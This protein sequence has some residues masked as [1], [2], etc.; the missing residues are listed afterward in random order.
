MVSGMKKL[1][2]TISII[3]ALGIGAVALNTV[4]PAGALGIASNSAADP[5]ADP[6]ACGPR[7]TFKGVLDKLVTDGTIT[8]TQ[9]DAVAQAMQDAVAAKH[10][11]GSGGPGARRPMA[12]R[13]IEGMIQVSADKI[14]VSVDDVKAA[15]QGGQSVADLANAHS[16]NP[17]D[18]ATAI[19]DAGTAKIDQAVAG[20]M[21]TQQQADL[22]TS[23]LPDAADR[24]VN[25]TKTC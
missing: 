8:Q 12:A 24:F 17:A 16:V 13:V 9:A 3:S 14:G 6:S 25:H 23:R 10:P 15:L 22:F 11:G 5:A 7:A 20:G 4:M 1:I 21:L 18:V 19:V 2:A